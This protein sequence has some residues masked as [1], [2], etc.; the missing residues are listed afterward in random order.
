M[1]TASAARTNNESVLA[2]G[3]QKRELTDLVDPG[4]ARHA[5]AVFYGADEPSLNSF[6][7]D[8]RSGPGAGGVGVGGG[9]SSK[10]ASSVGKRALSAMDGSYWR[11]GVRPRRRVADAELSMHNN[12]PNSGGGGGSGMDEQSLLHR[13]R[14]V[15]SL[16]SSVLRRA[17]P[18]P[19]S[20]PPSSGRQRSLPRPNFPRS[21]AA[22]VSRRGPHERVM[23]LEADLARETARAEAA[24]QRA[25]ELE[26]ALAEK[27]A[28]LPALETLLRTARAHF[29]AKERALR[30]QLAAALTG[31]T[32]PAYDRLDSETAMSPPTSSGSASASG[33]GTAVVTTT[34]ANGVANA[35]GNAPGH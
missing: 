9:G 1:A 35:N 28:A 27:T 14:R 5:F 32:L 31:R 2:W 7:Y 6:V 23:R 30:A 8:K 21:H 26:S 3:A 4:G 34:N 11:A 15:L 13:A 10:I 22:H 12:H 18:A 17:S 25:A 19:S 24:E 29:D 20:S 16:P 33:T